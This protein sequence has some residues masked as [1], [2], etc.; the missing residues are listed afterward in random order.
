M[1]T[2]PSRRGSVA[3]WVVREIS[4]TLMAGL[5]LI[6]TSWRWN[7]AAAWVLVG[8]YAA[9]FLAQA[10]ILIPRSPELL[11]ER[12]ERLRPDTKPWD[13]KLLPFYGISALALLV[14]AGL[15]LRLGWSH[16]L[17]A[18]VRYLGLG[19]ALLGNGIVT[20][21]MA[22]NSFFAF[23]VRIQKERGQKVATG[24][25][26][27]MVR[28][29]GYVGAILFALGTTLLLGSAWSLIPAAAAAL[30]LVTRTS[31]EDQ[32]LK[33]ELDGYAGYSEKTRFRLLPGIW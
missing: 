7:W 5:I 21:A 6:V 4:G 24:G 17:P 16:P 28:H 29:P 30:L 9:T 20:W 26:Y 31:L 25:P 2:G 8:I 14:I 33:A 13:K 12:S 27:R 10:V 32:T 19:L 3:R 18:S 11:A 15:D 1:T 23:S 22:V